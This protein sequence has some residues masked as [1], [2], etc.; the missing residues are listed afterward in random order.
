[1]PPTASTLDDNQTLLQFIEKFES[2][3]KSNATDYRLVNSTIIEITNEKNLS[4][5][6][7]TYYDY[8]GDKTL[9]RMETYTFKDNHPYA[10]TYFAAPGKFDD[11]LAAVQKMIDSFIIF[12]GSAGTE[13]NASSSIM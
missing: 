10:I 5:V 9:K 12:I 1:M 8:T 7:T 2:G 13:G 4:A 3:L 11:Y 6:Q